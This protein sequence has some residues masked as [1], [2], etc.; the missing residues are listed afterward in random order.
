MLYAGLLYRHDQVSYPA[1]AWKWAAATFRA[2]VVALIVIL[3]INPY[4]KTEQKVTEKPLV[5]LVSDNSNSFD[6]MPAANKSHCSKA[7]KTLQISSKLNPDCA[8]SIS[9]I[10]FS[11]NIHSPMMPRLPI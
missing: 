4:L 3:L 8:N 6:K 7:G 11:T 2:L 5:L 10:S 9:V 1:Q